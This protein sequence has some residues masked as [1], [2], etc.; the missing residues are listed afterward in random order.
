VIVCVPVAVGVNVAEQ[1]RFPLTMVHVVVPKV[2][3]RLLENVTVLLGGDFVP[4]AVSEMMAVHVVLLG[5]PPM[6]AAPGEQLTLVDVLRFVTVRLVV[7]LL[8]A[9]CGVSVPPP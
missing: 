1:L 5:V 3:P 6:I 2:P 8:P 4:V 9:N 7:P